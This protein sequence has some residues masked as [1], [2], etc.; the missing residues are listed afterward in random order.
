[1]AKIALITGSVR[2]PAV[3]PNVA[4]WVH[5][6]LKSRPSDEHEIEPV[7]IS[8][9]NL[10][11]YNESV[12]PAMVPAMAQFEHEH[13]KK[14]SAKIASFDAYIFVIPE[15]NY[16][17]AGG[18]KNAIDYLYNE[19]PGKPVAVFSYGNYGGSQANAH[20][21]DTL[22]LC[23]KMKVAP[24]KVLLPFVPGQ[25]VL[26]AVTQGALG[27]DSQKSWID[28]GKKDDI[29]KA[30]EEVKALLAEPKPEAPKA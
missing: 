24:T 27:E 8:D 22:E 20:L 26:S 15:Y 5:D 29:L 28:A 3:G 19:W 17:M 6:I 16:S 30:Y 18:F 1:M 12:M 9:Y 25:D 10:P 21:R 13:S 7:A 23:M 4:T 2:K 11:V 14:W